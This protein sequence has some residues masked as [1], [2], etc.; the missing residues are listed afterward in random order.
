M[1]VTLC[2]A[3]L[4]WPSNFDTLVGPLSSSNVPIRRRAVE[5]SLFV[6]S[7]A[8]GFFLRLS[9]LFDPPLL[10]CFSAMTKEVLE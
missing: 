7:D 10:D 2:F 9:V 4:V 6:I 8:E 1:T 5:I 3:V